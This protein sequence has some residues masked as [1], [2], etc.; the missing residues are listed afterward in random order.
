VSTLG[1]RLS[2]ETKAK[3]SAAHKGKQFTDEHRRRLSEAAAGRKMSPEVAEKIRRTKIDR[4][5]GGSKK[6]VEG[7]TC[8]RHV[9]TPEHQAK[10]TAAHTGRVKGPLPEETRRKIGKAR[11]GNTCASLSIHTPERRKRQGDRTRK[12]WVDGVFDHKHPCW[13][14]AGA[15]AGVRMRCLNSEGVFA[16]DCEAAGVLWKYEPRRFRLS[17]CTYRPDFYLPEFDI[18][19]EVKGYPEMPGNW[20]KKVES[21]RN[22]TGKTLIVVFM[23]ELSSLTYGGESDV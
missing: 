12:M 22:E 11:R 7:C 13:G 9:K 18:W 20:P 2:D 19:V 5:Q 15:H 23:K 4:G 3:M 10:I 21:F 17:W 1:C 8:R 14:K 16:Q 6:C